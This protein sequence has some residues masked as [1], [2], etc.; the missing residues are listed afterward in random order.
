MTDTLYTVELEKAENARQV[1]VN[2]ILKDGASSRKACKE[3]NPAKPDLKEKSPPRPYQKSV[4]FSAQVEAQYFGDKIEEGE[5]RR[6]YYIQRTDPVIEELRKSLPSN[7]ATPIL[8]GVRS[9][10]STKSSSS[11]V[12]SL[13]DKL[14]RKLRA[15]ST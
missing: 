7:V 4:K 1:A 5:M 2:G 10:P 6:S 11:S 9:A 12:T 3:E 14:Q 13:F 15:A 8:T